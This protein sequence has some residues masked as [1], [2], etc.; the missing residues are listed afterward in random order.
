[1]LLS[2]DLEKRETVRVK[3][4]RARWMARL[5]RWGLT[6]CQRAAEQRMWPKAFEQ[7]AADAVFFSNASY[8]RGSVQVGFAILQIAWRQNAKVSRATMPTLLT[9]AVAF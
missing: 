8:S 6:P 7:R 3:A 1:M 9:S 5:V 4:F 2:K